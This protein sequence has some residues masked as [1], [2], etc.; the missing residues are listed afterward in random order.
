MKDFFSHFSQS[1]IYHELETQ[2]QSINQENIQNIEPIIT[3]ENNENNENNQ[4]NQNNQNSKD[5]EN[6]VFGIMQDSSTT[7]QNHLIEHLTLKVQ[8]NDNPFPQLDFPKRVLIAF[9]GG[10]D[11]IV[12]MHQAILAKQKGI[13]ESLRATYIDHG[14]HQNSKE[15]GQF[16][17]DFCNQYNIPFT[18]HRIFLNKNDNDCI[19]NLEASARKARYAAL[20]FEQQCDEWLCTAQHLDDQ[21]ETFF[22]MLLRGSGLNGLASMSAYDEEKR[23]ARPLLQRYWTKDLIL[24]YAQHHHLSWVDDTSNQDMA[25]RRNW[26]RHDVLPNIEAQYPSYRQTMVRSIEHLQQV[27]KL[28]QEQIKELTL[29][30]QVPEAEVVKFCPYFSDEEHLIHLNNNRVIVGHHELAKFPVTFKEKSQAAFQKKFIAHVSQ[31][32]SKEILREWLKNAGLK[33]YPSLAQLEALWKEIEKVHQLD[34][35]F[36]SNFIWQNTELTLQKGVIRAY[37]KH[38]FL[39][40]TEHHLKSWIAQAYPALS[41][42]EL[43]NLKLFKINHRLDEYPL[44]SVLPFS[45]IKQRF[46]PKN[47]KPI[48]KTVKKIMQEFNIPV[49]VKPYLELYSVFP[50]MDSYHEKIE[51]INDDN[52]YDKKELFCPMTGLPLVYHIG[53]I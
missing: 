50:Q 19:K 45:R 53:G 31:L 7:R 49:W 16:C 9:S 1:L 30:T 12:L 24:S 23:M 15:W 29:K 22:I 5:E 43:L 28:Q 11:S 52:H 37:R 44:K 40:T 42:H 34:T 39:F 27:L 48:P 8:E 13:I 21:I 17:A 26:L 3:N 47:R 2:E 33:E 51:E 38:L 35:F 14:I 25:Y 18:T 41:E 36:S 6:P 4:N 20:K 32:T 10:V 46:V